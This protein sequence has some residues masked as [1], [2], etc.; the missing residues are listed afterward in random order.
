M[1]TAI[2]T[3]SV[4]PESR[5]SWCSGSCRTRSNN[6]RGLPSSVLARNTAAESPVRIPAG[7]VV[8]ANSS[9]EQ[10]SNRDFRRRRRLSEHNQAVRMNHRRLLGLRGTCSAG[11]TGCLGSE[12]AGT[13]LQTDATEP[14]ASTS[15][16]ADSRLEPPACPDRPGSFTRSSALKFAVQFEKSYLA[17]RAVRVVMRSRRL[18]CV[19]PKISQTR[20]RPERL[21]GGCPVAV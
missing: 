15:T 20:A 1:T 19:S 7:L 13:P 16:L 12:S 18:R 14:P 3:V 6:C 5:L 10:G 4:R 11:V 17:R 2:K 9:V 21:I 8:Q